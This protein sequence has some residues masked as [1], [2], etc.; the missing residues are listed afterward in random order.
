MGVTKKGNTKD[1]KKIEEPLIR[2]IFC[3]PSL[4]THLSKKDVPYTN[5]KLKRLHFRNKICSEIKYVFLQVFFILSEIKR[6]MDSCNYKPRDKNNKWYILT[7][8][9]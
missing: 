3:K 1:L 8:M 7:T 5:R 9:S 6:I 2:K 4:K